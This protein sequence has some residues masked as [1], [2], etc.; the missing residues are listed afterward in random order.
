MT[1]SIT[2]VVLAALMTT[3]VGCVTTGAGA[4]IPGTSTPP[5][6]S[7]ETLKRNEYTVLGPVTGK[8]RFK[9]STFL[10]FFRTQDPKDPTFD[11]TLFERPMAEAGGILDM[12]GIGK[13]LSF[14]TADHLPNVKEQAEAR[15]IHDALNK[16]PEA[17]TLITPRFE[18]TWK[19]NDYIFGAD[20]EA[21]VTVRGKAI[22]IKTGDMPYTQMYMP[23]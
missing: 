17:D 9:Y 21:E 14:L 1:K 6:L 7:V 3:S 16:L 18:W 20:Y 15:A 8:A 12:L 13:I 5:R 2:A 10:R 11:E 4:K 22:A 19:T 23:K